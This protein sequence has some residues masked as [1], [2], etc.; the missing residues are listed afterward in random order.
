VVSLRLTLTFSVFCFLL[1]IFFFSLSVSHF[2]AIAH[3]R[4]VAGPLVFIS[5]VIWSGLI[6]LGHQK[7]N[8]SASLPEK[9]CTPSYLAGVWICIQHQWGYFS[10]SQFPVSTNNRFLSE[11]KLNIG[12]KVKGKNIKFSLCLINQALCHEDI[13]GNGSI[14][15]PFLNSTLD[16]GEWSDSRPGC[17]THK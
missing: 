10:F 17:F 7:Q 5:F 6:L 14:T 2:L 16:E 9:T 4:P 12:C 3:T 1:H 8:R 15:P 13:W 11:T